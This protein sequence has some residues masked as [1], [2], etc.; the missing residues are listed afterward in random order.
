ML[1]RLR[2]HHSRAC[3]GSGRGPGSRRGGGG[4]PSV[5]LL[6]RGGLQHAWP[7]PCVLITEGATTDRRDVDRN[8][9]VYDKTCATTY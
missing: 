9:I 2:R 4:V 7:R 5:C 6:S 3:S 8:G 1:C